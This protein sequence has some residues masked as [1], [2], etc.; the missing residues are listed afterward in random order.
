M[1]KLS[2]SQQITIS[3]SV[4]ALTFG[5]ASY[6]VSYH[7]DKLAENIELVGQL[8]LPTSQASENLSS[9]I[10]KSLAALRGWLILADPEF[11]AERNEIWLR[12]IEPAFDQLTV[13]SSSWTNP[14]NIRRLNDIR[15]ELE[16]FKN[17][18]EEI[19]RI[20]HSI[21]ST[22][23]TKLLIE[24]AKPLADSVLSN[25]TALIEISSQATLNSKEQNLFKNMADF[26]GS[27]SQ[28]L[29]SIRLF[30]I[31]AD[32]N[33]RL[34]FER[35][36]KVNE[37]SFTRILGKAALMGEEQRV[38][39]GNLKEK[40]AEF[41]LL[42]RKLFAIRI[43][44]KYNIPNHLLKTKAAP[45]AKRI[46]VTLNDMV[47][48]QR[49][50]LRDEVAQ[51]ASEL[52]ILNAQVSFSILF[53]LLLTLILGFF[54][55]RSFRLMSR[56]I[57]Q[58][59]KELN[60]SIG[61]TEGILNTS[62]DAIVSINKDGVILSC[63]KTTNVMFGY[64]DSDIVGKNINMLMPE[65]YRNQH[66]GYLLEHIKTGVK[67]EIW[68]GSRELIAL[69]KNGECFPIFL[70][71]GSVVTDDEKIFTGFIRDITTQKCSQAELEELNERLTVRNAVQEQ[72]A[73][74]N[75]VMRGAN[76]LVT[77]GEDVVVAMSE[78]IGAGY[79]VLYV[80]KQ[81]N[82][83]DG[84]GVGVLSRVSAYGLN[85]DDMPS[86]DIK[87]GQGMVG[88]C[89]KTKST[90]H[91]TNIPEDYMTIR[92]G[93]GEA[94][95][96]ELIILPVT[97]EKK[98]LGV[99]ELATFKAV[100]N[101]QKETLDA[102]RE[103][104]GI[105]INNVLNIERTN[106]YLKK[107][108][109]QS[110]ELH[111]QS[112]RLK[113]SSAYKSDFLATMSHEIRTPINGVIGMLSSLV[114]TE[115][116]KD[117]LKKASMAKSSAQSLLVIINDILDFSKVDS[118][119]LD[120]E[121]LDFNLTLL[122]EDVA[123]IMAVKAQEKGLAFNLDLVD[124]LNPMVKGDA[125]RLRQIV[126][127]L[128]SNAIKF[129]HEGDITL[130]AKI[131]VHQNG[132]QLLICSVKDTGVG[133]SHE[134]QGFLFEAF[135]QADASTTREYGGTGLGLS[136]CKKL[137]ELMGGDI[138]AKSTKNK[139]SCF[140]F[141]IILDESHEPVSEVYRHE[142]SPSNIII[143]D[144][145]EVSRD[146]ICRQLQIWGAEVSSARDGETLMSTILRDGDCFDMLFIATDLPDIN[147][148]KL[149]EKIDKS[150]HAKIVLMFS[151]S[152]AR[153][154]LKYLDPF[155]HTSFTKPGTPS[156]LFDALSSLPQ[157]NAT[158]NN[159]T[160]T[161]FTP[162]EPSSDKE[163]ND[164]SELYAWPDNTRIM[165]VEDNYI[166]QETM[167]FLLEDIDLVADIASDGQE[168]L[169][170]LSSAVGQPFNLILMDCQ[171]P[172]MDGYTATTQIRNGA[173]SLQYQSI[174]IIALTANAMKNDRDNCIAAGMS[175]YL[176][177]PVD[178]DA[179]ATM[180]QK[181]LVENSHE[182]PK[183]PPLLQKNSEAQN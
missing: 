89:A 143:A 22:P 34:D 42:P 91:A 118:G 85:E 108:Q 16:Y 106:N 52:K 80:V 124:I 26:R 90:V 55:S 24:E 142:L 128:C 173:A 148:E 6:T 60:H 68:N 30:L 48:D 69:K 20:A 135:R 81:E 56:N 27:F 44:D 182:A 151:S 131:E 84:G 23:A 78:M 2:F 72:V 36:W 109:Q 35:N 105:V 136:I 1:N 163:S 102:V 76:N 137:C 15:Q 93:L 112:E 9:G 29:A 152:D 94:R 37:E 145:E 155:V 66:D 61:T 178:T 103:D 114:K 161:Y 21:E 117:Q 3:F 100:T 41:S 169:N 157:Y 168:A 43:S 129:T 164:P 172:I 174:P 87:V 18:Q 144:G 4:I 88:Q 104:I 177:K 77:L 123:E 119:K 132:K 111:K 46:L 5:V 49:G 147:T 92:S 159:L 7:T 8:R 95:P 75:E 97:F 71:I 167:K 13:L 170:M 154:Q 115:L 160:E 79:G 141:S 110:D 180:L 107:M 116:D 64:S 176:S 175:D 31:A 10:S 127:N 12:N 121:V 14:E 134:Q 181:W 65:P 25:I 171:M 113:E 62:K 165:L 11:K 86:L 126:T 162:Y 53:G 63:N 183:R 166:N 153:V 50:L 28:A 120:L 83:S 73:K 70:S 149:L 133:M 17:S 51:N 140:E 139:G 146:I 74:I 125:S 96:Q 122:M 47:S 98:L 67:K 59:N 150:L 32:V 39:V 57:S 38:L 138:T 156:D 40:R 158:G 19:S 99:I 33:A 130:K 82:N 45:S 179:L 54:T 58:K 101:E